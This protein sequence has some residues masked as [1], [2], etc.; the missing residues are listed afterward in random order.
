M[1]RGDRIAIY[2]PG[3]G[4]WGKPDGGD[5]SVR[6]GRQVQTVESTGASHLKGSLVERGSLAASSS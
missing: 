3:G 6:S 1:G 4:G 5:G 2:T